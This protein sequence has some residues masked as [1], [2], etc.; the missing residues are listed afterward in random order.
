MV[1][2]QPTNSPT[3]RQTDIVIFRTAIATK[4]DMDH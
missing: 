2:F 4:K 1:I 3:Q